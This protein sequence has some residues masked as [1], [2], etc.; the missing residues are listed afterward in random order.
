MTWLIESR[1]L[2][3]DADIKLLKVLPFCLFL[4]EIKRKLLQGEN[5]SLTHLCKVYSFDFI[6]NVQIGMDLL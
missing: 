4:L 1:K 6:R 2:D 5:I 3:S